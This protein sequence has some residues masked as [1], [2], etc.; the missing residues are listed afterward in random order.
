MI[1]YCKTS[2]P[3]LLRLNASVLNPDCILA[4]PVIQ[5]RNMIQMQ[6]NPNW[7]V[8]FVSRYCSPSATIEILSSVVLLMTSYSGIRVCLVLMWLLFEALKIALLCLRVG[9]KRPFLIMGERMR[10]NEFDVSEVNE[11]ELLLTNLGNG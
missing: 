6:K 9:L 1:N 11:G 3:Y 8:G 2:E 10:M 4:S 5:N 7:R